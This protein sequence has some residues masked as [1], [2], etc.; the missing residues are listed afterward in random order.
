[1]ELPFE[2]VNQLPRWDCPGELMRLS[3]PEIHGLGITR[4]PGGGADRKRHVVHLRV[5]DRRL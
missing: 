5:A 2:L 4:S 3:G 1:M